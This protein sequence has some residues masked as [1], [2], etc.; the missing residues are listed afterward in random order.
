MNLCRRNIALNYVFFNIL[1]QLPYALSLIL[2]KHIGIKPESVTLG[3]KTCIC[4]NFGILSFVDYL[5]KFTPE[6]NVKYI[7]LP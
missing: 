4:H 3:D 7:M 1:L 2:T 5:Q 6:V